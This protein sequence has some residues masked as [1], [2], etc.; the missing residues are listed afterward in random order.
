MGNNKFISEGHCGK[1]YPI[2]YDKKRAPSA[3]GSDALLKF[4]PLFLA[5]LLFPLANICVFFEKTKSLWVMTE[6]IVK[7]THPVRKQRQ[8]TYR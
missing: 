7:S 6:A 2:R 8:R 3:I 1:M 5:Y 4:K